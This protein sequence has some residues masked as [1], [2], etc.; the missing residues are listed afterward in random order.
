MNPETEEWILKAEG[1][2]RTMRREAVV[3][4]GPNYDAVCFHAQQCVEKYLKALLFESEIQ[5]PK[6][7]DLGKLLSLLRE[8]Y[9]QL[10]DLSDKALVLTAFAVEFR[11]PGELAEIDDSKE[12]VTYCS[13]IRD[14]LRSLLDL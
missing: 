7:H 12:A 5:F 1:D 2:W 8:A 10:Q 11:Y 13:E 3:T 9:P 14:V 4:D 6:I